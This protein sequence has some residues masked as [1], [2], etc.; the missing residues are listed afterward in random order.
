M[1]IAII[2][3]DNKKELMAQFCT[4]YYGI[5]NRHNNFFFCCTNRRAARASTIRRLNYNFERKLFPYFFQ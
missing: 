1:D 3:D 4:A 2:A 5:F